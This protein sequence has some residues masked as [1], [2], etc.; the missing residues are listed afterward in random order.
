MK[1]KPSAEA[2]FSLTSAGTDTSN[3]GTFKNVSGAKEDVDSYYSKA[4]NIVEDKGKLANKRQQEALSREQWE[5]PLLDTKSR[6]NGIFGELNSEKNRLAMDPHY[7]ENM[8]RGN[9]RGNLNGLTYE[10]TMNLSRAADALNNKRWWKP[11]RA[12]LFTKK[13][14]VDRG[15]IGSSERWEPIETQEMRQMRQNEGV[16]AYVRQRDAN[17][18]ANVQDYAQELR[19]K[20]DDSIYTIAN[21]LGTSDVNINNA[22]RNGV[23]GLNI[24]TL[25]A[26][27]LG[28]ATSEIISDIA[29]RTK[30]RL[31]QAVAENM[32]KNPDAVS[33]FVSLFFT[34]TATPGQRDIAN[35][36]FQNLIYQACGGDPYIMAATRSIA[37]AVGA[38]L[39]WQYALNG[40]RGY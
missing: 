8:G 11:G 7:K 35:T 38:E 24:N 33:K 5:Q 29:L 10:S 12:G 14:G 19:R 28:F 13:Y 36:E 30:N 4:D 1:I 3:N 20:A 17:R 31:L 26:T 37:G 18:Q 15:E 34:G 9:Y 25:S 23:V 40:S 27:Q 22:I 16:E 6:A 39:Q 21:L 2:V 32:Q